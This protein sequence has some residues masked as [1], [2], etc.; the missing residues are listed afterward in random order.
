MTTITTTPSPQLSRTPLLVGLGVVGVI[1]VTAVVVP[2]VLPQSTTT[3]Q[4][5]TATVRVPTLA[6]LDPAE[7]RAVAA[8]I[9]EA[10]LQRT[11]DLHAKSVAHQ[12]GSGLRV[13][14]RYEATTQVPGSIG[15]YTYDPTKS[16]AG[17]RPEAVLQIPGKLGTYPYDPARSASSHTTWTDSFVPPYN[18]PAWAEAIYRHYYGTALPTGGRGGAD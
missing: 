18:D 16:V 9:A 17:V 7:R 5:S 11:I 3:T 6:E 12:S 14:P 8:A 15:A 1:A 13:V 2:K 4:T 10:Q